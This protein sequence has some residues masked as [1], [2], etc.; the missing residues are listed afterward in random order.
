MITYLLCVFLISNSR[1]FS[2]SDRS[3]SD[4]NF[5]STMWMALSEGL[6]QSVHINI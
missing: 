4:D 3:Y 2:Q 6:G 1:R 5:N